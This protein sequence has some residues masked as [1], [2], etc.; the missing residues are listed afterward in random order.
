MTI[1]LIEFL[2]LIKGITTNLETVKSAQC[3]TAGF[4]AAVTGSVFLKLGYI[5]T[6]PRIV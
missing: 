5:A 4:D 2:A 1:F 3:H 6:R